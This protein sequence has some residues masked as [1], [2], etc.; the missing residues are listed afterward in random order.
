VYN[1]M[2]EQ[3]ARFT[4]NAACGLSAFAAAASIMLGMRQ[5]QIQA[6]VFLIFALVLCW[7]SL[8]GYARYKKLRDARWKT[9]LKKSEDE[10][11]Q[12]LNHARMTIICEHAAEVH[13]DAALVTSDR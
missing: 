13:D 4:F 1:N 7:V 8:S 6:A 2:D 9:E 3:T 10:L 11:N 5:L 12:I